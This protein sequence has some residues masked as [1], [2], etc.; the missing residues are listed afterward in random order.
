MSSGGKREGAGRPKGAKNKVPAQGRKKI[1]ASITIS[2]TPEEVAKI[3]LLAKENNKSVSRFMLEKCL[4][5][6]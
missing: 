6:V 3:K 5:N 4:E 2:G 1:F